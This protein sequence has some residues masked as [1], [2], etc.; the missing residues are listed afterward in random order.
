MGEGAPMFHLRP[1]DQPRPPTRDDLWF[2]NIFEATSVRTG[3]V[4]RRKI[5]DVERTVG[6]HALEVEVRRRGYHL[7]EAG[8]QF[9][10]ICSRN[11]IR[12]IC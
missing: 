7:I 4:V 3:G 12:L 5:C 10:I 11:D 8:S 6:R 2:Q 9:I 1:I